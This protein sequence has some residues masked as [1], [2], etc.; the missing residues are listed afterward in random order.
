MRR[1]AELTTETLDDIPGRCRA[2]LFW[3]LGVTRPIDRTDDEL[4]GDAALQKLAWWR[5][6]EL[7]TGPPG[8]VIRIDGEF[9]AYCAFAEPEAYAPRLALV[10]RVSQDALLLATA[11]V[12]P[13][14]RGAGIGRLLVQA[15]LKEALRRDR[16][17]VEAY[18]DRRHREQACVLPVTWLLHEG[19]EV[20]REHPRYPLLRI[21]VRSIARFAEPIEAALE[22]A[23]ARLQRR[24][25]PEP[26][27]NRAEPT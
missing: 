1:V 10:P 24:V 22:A 19:F 21:D 7:E 3:E 26:V 12:E 11:W 2:C 18:G 27:P 6:T 16:K 4:A 14:H 5:S 8:R 9:A 20:A 23:L 15:A 25:A 13:P 17:A